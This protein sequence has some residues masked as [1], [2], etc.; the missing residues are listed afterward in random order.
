MRS[1]RL[2]PAERRDQIIDAAQVLFS[3][4]DPGT[5]T[6]DQIAEAAGVSR[7]L[8]YNYFG[9][10][11]GV[12]AAV[13][14]QSS[15]RLDAALAEC[16]NAADDGPDRLRSI[17]RAYLDFA[18]DNAGACRLISAS[19]ANVHPL[20]RSARRRRFEQ[21]AA[22]W[23]DSPTSRLLARSVVSLLE[24]AALECL[25]SDRLDRDH[26]E[27]VLYSLVWSGLSGSA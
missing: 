4:H 13:Y 18:F 2:E 16:F 17:I 7:A 10:K 21:I 24:G 23:G 9:D 15:Q 1:T 12:I 26:A 8:V 20:V 22:V 25:E 11:G 14:L 19:E 5:V 3:D 6:F 27:R